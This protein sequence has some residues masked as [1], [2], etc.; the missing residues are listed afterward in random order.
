MYHQLFNEFPIEYYQVFMIISNIV[1]NIFEPF[2]F[3]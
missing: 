1:M 2:N 3:V